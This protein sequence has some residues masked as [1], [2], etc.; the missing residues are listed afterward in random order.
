MDWTDKVPDQS[1]WY[2]WCLS[3]SLTPV[4]VYVDIDR[5]FKVGVYGSYGISLMGGMWY[6]PITVHLPGKIS[7]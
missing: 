6:G 4:V 3:R 2:W 5:A 7:G 1:G